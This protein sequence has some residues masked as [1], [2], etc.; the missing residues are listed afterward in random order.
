MASL[1]QGTT[2]T[3]DGAAILATRISVS[4]GDPGAGNSPR[5]TVSHL[6]SDPE[7]EEPYELTWA[8]PDDSGSSPKTIQIDYMGSSIEPSTA[9]VSVVI[10]GP[11]AFNAG[12]TV[13]SSSVT[14]Q[15]GDVIRGTA[16]FRF[17]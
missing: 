17:A 5:V 2:V 7:K 4:N 14:A 15:V 3:V 16:T 13:V 6:G 8:A 9:T 10:T 11:I 1:A 12:C